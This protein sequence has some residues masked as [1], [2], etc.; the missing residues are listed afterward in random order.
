M[1]WIADE[2]H[3]LFANK[4]EK[5]RAVEYCQEL[6]RG[7]AGSWRQVVDRFNKSDRDEVRFWCLQV[8]QEV[9]R[10]PL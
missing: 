6:K 3:V 10:V 8:I 9:R 1:A 5:E 4:N 7:A 2:M